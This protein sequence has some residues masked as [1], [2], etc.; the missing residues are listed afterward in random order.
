[1]IKFVDVL[2]INTT[3]EYH[4]IQNT[5]ILINETKFCLRIIPTG[6]ARSQIVLNFHYK[7]NPRFFTV[8]FQYVFRFL[9]NTEIVYCRSKRA[10]LELIFGENY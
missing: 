5:R 10:R 1:M 8:T 2:H 9:H 6:S 3:R 7:T 4:F